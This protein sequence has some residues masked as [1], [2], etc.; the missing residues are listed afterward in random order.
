[1][2]RQRSPPRSP[3]QRVYDELGEMRPGYDPGVLLSQNFKKV[4]Q[5]LWAAFHFGIPSHAELADFCGVGVNGTGSEGGHSN[6]MVDVGIF[7]RSQQSNARHTDELAVKKFLLLAAMCI[8]EPTRS[9]YEER[10]PVA[11][12]KPWFKQLRDSLDKFSTGVHKDGV[13]KCEKVSDCKYPSIVAFVAEMT[14]N[15]LNM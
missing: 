3:A 8:F 6:T 5:H 14:S 12:F 1:M 7:C 11:K 13:S 9:Y 2:L 10:C 4:D 15:Y